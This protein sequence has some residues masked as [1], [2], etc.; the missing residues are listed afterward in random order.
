MEQ[1]AKGKNDYKPLGFEGHFV[2]FCNGF[3]GDAFSTFVMG[4]SLF[5]CVNI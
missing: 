1:R 5:L 2:H 3:L 4:L